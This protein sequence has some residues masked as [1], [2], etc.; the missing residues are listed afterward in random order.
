MVMRFGTARCPR[1]RARAGILLPT[2]ADSPL[3]VM[4]GKEDASFTALCWAH[5]HV[6]SQWRLFSCG[7]DGYVVEW[8][9]RQRQPL[10]TS[11]TMGGAAWHMAAQPVQ[12]PSTSADSP[13][14]DPLVA[15]ATDDGAVRLLAAEAG[16]PGLR[17]HSTAGRADAR[18]LCVAW[19]PDGTMVY[20]G[21]SD[22]CIRA[23]DVK[24]GAAPSKPAHLSAGRVYGTSRSNG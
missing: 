18:A 5:D 3:Q 2:M 7:L 13:V 4:P 11:S 1:L 8:D 15:L 20:A 23:M 10:A 14:D 6:T 19:R 21:F 12:P 9:L 24:S 16:Q 17:Y 22:G